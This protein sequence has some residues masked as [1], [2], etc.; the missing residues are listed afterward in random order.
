[1]DALTRT[2]L[3]S[4]HG[5]PAGR[6]GTA[7]ADEPPAAR[8]GR[9]RGPDGQRGGDRG[10]LRGDGGRMG[11]GRARAMRAGDGG[12]AMS[13]TARL[14]KENPVCLHLWDFNIY[15]QEW[16]CTRCGYV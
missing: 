9:I 12:E 3:F 7:L 11:R 8:M 5:G 14:P 16:V 4:G 6:H 10:A 13:L 2:P 15:T 1:M